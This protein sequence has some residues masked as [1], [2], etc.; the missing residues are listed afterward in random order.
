MLDYVSSLEKGVSAAIAAE[1]NKKEIRSV[2]DEFR[3]QV[4]DGTEGKIEIAIWDLSANTPLQNVVAAIANQPSLRGKYKAIAASNPLAE[5]H[6]PKEL[7]RWTQDR[8][9]YPCKISFADTEYICEDK[10]SLEHNLSLLL[11]DPLTGEK[12]HQLM[13]LPIER[14]EAEVEDN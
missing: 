10:E 8:T 13:N 4:L 6:E 11:E 5:E 3:E 7:A 1:D 9:G 14:N 12:L 2:F